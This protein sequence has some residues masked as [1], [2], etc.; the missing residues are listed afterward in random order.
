MV[1]PSPIAAARTALGPLLLAIV[2]GLMALE[3]TASRLARVDTHD[4]DETAASF[5]IAFG[6]QII[7]TMEAAVV[8]VPLFLAYNHRL[9]DIDLASPLAWIAF[10]VIVEF[11][12]YWHHRASHQVRWLWA[13]H[14]VHHSSTRINLTAGIRLGWTAGLS[15]HYLIYVPLALIGFHPIAI[16]IALSLNLGYQFFIHSEWLP[17]LGFFE[18]ILNSPSH[19]RLHHACNETCL[20]KNFGGTL[21]VFD[22]LFGTFTEQPAKETLRYGLA[23]QA[24]TLNPFKIV[25]GEW[26]AMFAEFRAAKSGWKQRLSILFGPPGAGQHSI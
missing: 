16:V 10:F 17:R 8:S 12:Y 1:D 18:W 15:G 14:A 2:V 24:R 3:Y 7:R 25:F 19:H 13:T 22:R 4:I 11:V 21:I 26:L 23:G 5:V 6:H 9:F 20:D